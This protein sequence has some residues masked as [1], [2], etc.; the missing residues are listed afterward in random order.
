MNRMQKGFTLI[1]LMIVI[2]IIGI[3]AAVALPAYQ[4]YTVRAKLSGV[5]ARGAEAK[6][7]VA[8]AFASKGTLPVDASAPF[9]TSG[10]GAVRLVTWTGGAPGT[11]KITLTVG[12]TGTD[13]KVVG[14]TMELL[15]TSTASSVISWKC[16]AGTVG[17][18]IAP[19][20]LPGSCK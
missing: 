10:A 16:Q 20:Y 15:I 14:K 12:A 5:L 2:A 3:L 7:S 11:A 18:A 13:P 1:E 17:T 6:T 8:E 19:K 4:D 9:N